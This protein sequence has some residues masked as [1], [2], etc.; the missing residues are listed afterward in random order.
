MVIGGKFSEGIDFKHQLA[1]IIFVIGIPLANISD[2]YIKSKKNYLEENK[3]KHGKSQPQTHNYQPTSL[4][5]FYSWYVNKAIVQ[6]NQAIGRIK[7]S[8]DDFG[9]IFLIDSRY[10]NDKLYYGFLSQHYSYLEKK[11]DT[12]FDLEKTLYNFFEK[13]KKEILTKNNNPYSSNEVKKIIIETK[14][15]NNSKNVSKN[16]ADLLNFMIES[17]DSH[18]SVSKSKILIDLEDNSEEECINLNKKGYRNTNFGNSLNALQ[19]NKSDKLLN[20]LFNNK[21]NEFKK[22]T[23]MKPNHYK[24]FDIKMFL[25]SSDEPKKQKEL[26]QKEISEMLSKKVD[27]WSKSANDS[28]KKKN[29]MM[30]SSDNEILDEYQSSNKKEIVS[31][32][33]KIYDDKCPICYDQ[34]TEDNLN[35]FYISK[36]CKHIACKVC[37]DHSLK[38]KIECMICKTRVRKK[39]LECVGKYFVPN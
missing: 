18:K 12:F 23:L 22:N 34:L 30:K 2:C 3:S 28:I 31:K 11:F 36:K 25:P 39:F 27:E 1:R 20:P 15:D 17:D 7:R 8:E 19:S 37:W 29:N 4:P 26:T 35:D 6:V 33:K 21:K 38:I 5:S 14:S 24:K 32:I 13:N 16:S 9:A 10:K